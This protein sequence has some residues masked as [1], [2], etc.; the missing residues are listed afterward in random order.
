MSKEE[1]QL[2]QQVN[3]LDVVAMS[4]GRR[5]TLYCSECEKNI[6]HSSIVTGP[7]QGWPYCP[8]HRGKALTVIPAVFDLEGLSQYSTACS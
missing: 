5:G 4:V 8:V 7:I 2:E 3:R 6:D 1:H